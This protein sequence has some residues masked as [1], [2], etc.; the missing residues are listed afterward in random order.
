MH[1]TAAV[2]SPSRAMHNTDRVN[3]NQYSNQRQHTT[4]RQ[5]T[6]PRHQGY[7]FVQTNSLARPPNSSSHTSTSTLKG[8]SS[9]KGKKGHSKTTS[10]PSSIVPS[11]A[12]L[13]VP[14]DCFVFAVLFRDSIPWSWVAHQRNTTA[15]IF[16]YLP[17]VL[18]A[19]LDIDSPAINTLRLERYAKKSSVVPLT[20]YVAYAPNATAKALHRA[21]TQKSSPLYSGDFGGVSAE[22]IHEIDSTYDPLWYMGRPK[23]DHKHESPRVS[24]QAIAGSVGGVGGAAALGIL[25]FIF[26]Q[27]VRRR[28]MIKEDQLLQ[29]RC[30][31]QSFSGLEPEQ[32]DVY[33]QTNRD[34]NGPTVNASYS[35]LGL[36]NVPHVSLGST[37]H[38]SDVPESPVSLRTMTSLRSIYP[39]IPVCPPPTNET[40]SSEPPAP[41]KKVLGKAL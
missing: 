27:R 22:L 7:T 20:L 4:H 39:A 30:T 23:D 25:Y 6:W 33:D 1:H 35:S 41:V 36:A 26:Q 29:R 5:Y 16:S 37:V 28:R 8:P 18:A 10:Y 9:T 19:A 13:T 14:N 2:A 38:A 31:I 15:Q 32:E 34:E 40:T 11:E 24:D 21:V 3:N 17:K 12:D